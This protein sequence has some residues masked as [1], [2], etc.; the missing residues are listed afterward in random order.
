[1]PKWKHDEKLSAFDE[2]STPAIPGET[3]EEDAQPTEK[4]P[5]HH[6]PVPAKLPEYSRA[7]AAQRLS[8]M[9][10]KPSVG[11]SYAAAHRPLHPTGWRLRRHVKRRNLRLTNLSYQ[12]TDRAGIRWA[13]LPLG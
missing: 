9:P 5:V 10:E 8:Q 1:M 12:L 3:N 7:A 11:V 2:N 6:A 13:I 4:F